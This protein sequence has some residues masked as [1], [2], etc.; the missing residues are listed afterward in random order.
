MIMIESDIKTNYDYITLLA[1]R[2]KSFRL[3]A[4]MS[5]R[6][7]AEQSGVSLSTIAHFE[8]GIV[9]NMSLSNFISLLR[10]VGLDSRIEDLVPELPMPDIALRT[11]NKY[12]PK[13]KRKH[14]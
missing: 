6:E 1:G 10:V 3:A 4:R 14:D 9:K 2:I 8:Q 7:M 13:R 12:I 5:Q 11:L